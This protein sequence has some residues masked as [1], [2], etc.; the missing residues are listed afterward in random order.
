M[1]REVCQHNVLIENSCAECEQEAEEQRKREEPLMKKVQELGFKIEKIVY[2]KGFADGVKSVQ[3]SKPKRPVS[4]EMLETVIHQ[5]RAW[6][7]L[8]LELQAEIL[9]DVKKHL[10]KAILAELELKTPN[11]S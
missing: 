10:A 7:A 11:H 3:E 8:H 2:D 1:N 9:A 4:Q 5:S 6:Q